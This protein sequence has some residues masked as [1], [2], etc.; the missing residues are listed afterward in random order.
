M[1]IC[2]C[3]SIM[4]Q[5]SHDEEQLIVNKHP[6]NGPLSGTTRVSR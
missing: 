5:L 1:Y 4:S 6:F 3:R 2:Q